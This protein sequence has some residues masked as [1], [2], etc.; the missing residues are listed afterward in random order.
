MDGN[1]YYEVLNMLLETGEIRSYN[2]KRKQES[3]E[4]MVEAQGREDYVY[5]QPF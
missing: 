4:R 5:D 1:S 2:T 3:A